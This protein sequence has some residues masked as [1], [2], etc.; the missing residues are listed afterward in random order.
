M[1]TDLERKI[2]ALLRKAEGSS[3]E[4][5]ADAFMRKAQEL[6][7][8]HGID[9]E[10]LWANDPSRREKIEVAK[11]KIAD[12]KPGSM[13]RRI[14]LSQVA[15]VNHSKMW[16]TPGSDYSSIAG[17]P[18]DLLFVEML[19]TSIITQMNFKEAMALAH[20]NGVHPKTFRSNFAAG[21]ADR[22]NERLMENFQAAQ[23]AVKV[24]EPGMSI[25]LLDRKKEVDNWVKDKYNLRAGSAG[26]QG[27]YNAGARAAG[28]SA[29]NST[30]ISGGRGHLKSRKALT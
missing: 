12:N 29:A 15:R 8:R 13:H 17:Y 20:S 25:A 4:E 21:F 6:M 3:F 18:N 26:N 2:R 23:A 9:E 27:K 7:F 19:F 16:Y 1:E 11:I 10:R 22:I 24:D 28:Q 5:E 14:I 30:D